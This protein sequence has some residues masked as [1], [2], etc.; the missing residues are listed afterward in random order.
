M[1]RAGRNSAARH[2]LVLKGHERLLIFHMQIK[3][4]AEGGQYASRIAT[5]ACL[6]RSRSG[7]QF[8]SRSKII[9]SLLR[10]RAGGVVQCT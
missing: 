1:P 10:R 2:L 9:F 4:T 7:I 8:Q 3:L 5:G 6:H